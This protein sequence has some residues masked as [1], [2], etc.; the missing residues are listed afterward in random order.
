MVKGIGLVVLPPGS[1]EAQHI[2]IFTHAEIRLTATDETSGHPARA[3]IRQA[4][5][6]I[7]T[8][9][10]RIHGIDVIVYRLGQIQ[11]TGRHV[12]AIAVAHVAQGFAETLISYVH[13]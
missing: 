11:S 13:R 8:M 6:H 4:V 1:N 9:D 12:H 5:R 7:D 10:N 3:P 2:T